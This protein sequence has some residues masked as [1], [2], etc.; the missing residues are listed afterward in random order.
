LNRW[1]EYFKQL[2][3]GEEETEDK[4]EEYKVNTKQQNGEQPRPNNEQNR[5]IIQKLKKNNKTLVND[6]IPNC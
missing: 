5:K 4:E 3:N 6:R 1:R 2:F